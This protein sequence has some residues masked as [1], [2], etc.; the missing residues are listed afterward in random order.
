MLF[1]RALL[2]YTVNLLPFK[3]PGTTM[4]AAI[5]ERLA[6]LEDG[7]V[8]KLWTM[9]RTA[10]RLPTVR[11]WEKRQVEAESARRERIGANVKEELRRGNLPPARM[12]GLSH[13]TFACTLMNYDVMS[14]LDICLTLVTSA[15][16]LLVTSVNIYTKFSG[17]AALLVPLV[18]LAKSADGFSRVRGFEPSWGHFFSSS[19]LPLHFLNSH[20]NDQGSCHTHL[21]SDTAC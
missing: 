6:L 8:R 10:T 14:C 11:D 7:K 16:C 17:R 20:Y 2:Q 12:F 9:A 13:E 18:Y 3:K 15:R 1:D 4:V 19:A 5:R 21:D